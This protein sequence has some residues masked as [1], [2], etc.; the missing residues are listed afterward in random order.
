MWQV[1]LACVAAAAFVMAVIVV[2]R[3]CDW[4]VAKG[5]AQPRHRRR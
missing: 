4:L 3:I 5:L 2:I 1:V